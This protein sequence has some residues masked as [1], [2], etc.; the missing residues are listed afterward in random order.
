AILEA[1][2]ILK[3]DPH[4]RAATDVSAAAPSAESTN[5]AASPSS[6]AKPE[7]ASSRATPRSPAPAPAREKSAPPVRP[8]EKIVK[9]PAPTQAPPPAASADASPQ[10]APAQ[11]KPVSAA[12]PPAATHAPV[13]TGITHQEIPSVPQRSLATI[14][15]TVRVAVRVKLDDTG[16]VSDASFDHEGPSA[17]FSRISLNAARDW[18][19]S[20]DASREWVLHFQF[21]RAGA[22]VEA[23]P[24]AN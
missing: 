15:G 21:T 23:T 20:P 13:S 11:P 22:H 4:A 10:P 19:F 16:S 17:Y 14:T 3:H 12:T 7:S 18:K 6:P 2:R 9:S 1:P 8:A 24:A 5:A